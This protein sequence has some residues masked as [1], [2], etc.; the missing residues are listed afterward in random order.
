MHEVVLSIASNVCVEKSRTDIAEDPLTSVW[1]MGPARSHCTTLMC[2][3]CYCA[4]IRM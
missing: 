4:Q 3:L 1:V 2:L